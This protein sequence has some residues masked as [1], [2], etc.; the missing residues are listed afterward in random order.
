MMKYHIKLVPDSEPNADGRWIT[1]EVAKPVNWHGSWREAGVR[2]AEH[3]PKGEHL[4][5]FMT[6]D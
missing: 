3:I 4:V 2:F 5:Q 1:I 6:A